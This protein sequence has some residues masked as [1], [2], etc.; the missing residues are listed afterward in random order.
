MALIIRRALPNCPPSEAE[1]RAGQKMRIPMTYLICAAFL[2]LS[3]ATITPVADAAPVV[4]S[5]R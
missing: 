2:A 3:L 5:R 1:R 4:A